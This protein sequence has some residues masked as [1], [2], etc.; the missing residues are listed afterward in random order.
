MPYNWREMTALALRNVG[1][2]RPLLRLTAAA[3][4]LGATVAGAVVLSAHRVVGGQHSC[5][6]G[7]PANDCVYHPRPG[8]VLP[9]M[10]GIVVL[11]IAGAAG[12]LV[13]TRR[14]ST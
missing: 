4:I 14:R 8:W 1:L 6:G 13:A 3:L 9:T 11:G 12:L 7:A 2:F 5:P 10:A